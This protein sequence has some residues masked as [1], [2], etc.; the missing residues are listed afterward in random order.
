[1]INLSEEFEKYSDEYMEFKRIESPA[2]L[3]PDICAFI[4]LHKL[5]PCV[6][7]MVTWAGH[8]EI[9]LDTNPDELAKMA[10][11][12]DIRDLVRCGVRY[13]DDC[14]KMFV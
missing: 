10:T 14:L 11:S 5:V 2:H 13:S 8:D 12:D 7:D 3:C 4:M 1:M 9:A 6:G